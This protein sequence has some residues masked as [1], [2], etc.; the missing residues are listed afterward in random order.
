MLLVEKKLR[1]I[2]FRIVSGRRDKS[3]LVVRG[4]VGIMRETDYVYVFLFNECSIDY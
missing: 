4:A 3:T 1:E 2:F